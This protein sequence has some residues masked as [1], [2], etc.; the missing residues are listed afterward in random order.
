MTKLF[1]HALRI[2]AKGP[3]ALLLASVLVAAASIDLPLLA[4]ASARA[5]SLDDDP[6]LV[7]WWKF[8]EAT[9][10]TAADSSKRAHQGTLEG[11]LSFDATS[12]PGRV[13][14]A[15]KF[16]GSKDG[17]RIAGYKGITGTQ[18][19]SVA[20][21]IK[22]A[23]SSGDLVCWGTNEHGKMWTF[24]HVRG[25]V[26][27]TPK[28]GYLYMKAGTHDDAWH[29]VAVTVQAA[30]LPNLHDHVKLYRDGEVA[31]IDDIG[32]LDLWPIET[33]D[34]LDVIIGRGFKGC[35]DDL[36]LYDRAL[37]EEEIKALFRLQSDRPLTQPKEKRNDP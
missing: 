35:L 32:L 30:E 23:A 17:V 5:V 20:V 10:K 29:H 13:G 37:S 6:H 27:V 4:A 25:R 9:G 1:V 31:E 15:L 33:G 26:G 2:L 19:R 21:W 28:G 3:A 14:K 8:D 36:R 12:V 18:A 22:T 24:G 7:G 34:S 11:G 16:P